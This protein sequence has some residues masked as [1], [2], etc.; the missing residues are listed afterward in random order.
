MT[1]IEKIIAKIEEDC[2]VISIIYCWLCHT[3]LQR[4]KTP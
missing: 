3:V 2:E 1:G 4:L